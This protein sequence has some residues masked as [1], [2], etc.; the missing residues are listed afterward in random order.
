MVTQARLNNC[1]GTFTGSYFIEMLLCFYQSAQLFKFSFYFCTNL[2]TIFSLVVQSKTIKCCILIKNIYNLKFML[3]SQHFIILI[4]GWCYFQTP[5]TKFYI[6]ISIFYDRNHSVANR[7]NGFF[8]F[9]MSKTLIIWVYT[10]GS[11]TKYSFWTCCG[12]GKGLIAV[13]YVVGNIK[14]V[15][16]LL[17]KMY[18]LVTQGCFC[19]W[20]PVDHSI[21]PV[22]E[23][24]VI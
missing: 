12:N 5:S 17:Y 1:F 2:K 21:A 24:F 8:P 3:I 13:L 18:F 4:M 10:N 23:S 19:L 6:N 20:I 22:N 14:Q 15:T 7:H 11:I 16:L 9:Q